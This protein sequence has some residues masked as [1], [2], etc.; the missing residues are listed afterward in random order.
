MLWH[1]EEELYHW[2]AAHTRF[3]NSYWGLTIGLYIRLNS[4][5]I[6]SLR[7]ALSRQLMVRSII[8]IIYC[9]WVKAIAHR[10][11]AIENHCI[12]KVAPEVDKS[13]DNTVY[14]RFWGIERAKKFCL[15]NQDWLKPKYT[16]LRYMNNHWINYLFEVFSNFISKWMYKFSVIF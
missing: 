6:V 5:S 9:V 16:S 11:K 4:M 2:I 1:F 7:L 14:P 3:C 13:V 10:A 8:S 15:Q 12:S